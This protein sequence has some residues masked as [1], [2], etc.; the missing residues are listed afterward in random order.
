MMDRFQLQTLL[1]HLQPDLLRTTAA[2]ASWGYS[3]APNSLVAGYGH[4]L[5]AGAESAPTIPLPTK[6]WTPRCRSI[7]SAGATSLAPLLLRFR[8][9]GELR[10]PTSAAAGLA[11]VNVMQNG[12]TV[13]SGVLKV[14]PIAPGIFSMNSTGS[15]VAAAYIQR[16]KPDGTFPSGRTRRSLRQWPGPVGASP[17]SFNGDTLFLLLFGSGFDTATKTDVQAFV[18]NA[19]ADVDYAGVQ[20]STWARIRST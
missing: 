13:S 15:G 3:V 19:R 9:A 7:D 11:Q 4:Q 1:D 20:G 2:T 5:A 18:G 16:K 8:P 12:V 14:A 10:G 17:I 6:L